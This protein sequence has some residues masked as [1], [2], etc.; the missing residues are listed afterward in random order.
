MRFI[1]QIKSHIGKDLNVPEYK[2]EMIYFKL[3]KSGFE[4]YKNN[5]F[6]GV[7]NKNYRV[8]T[9]NQKYSV[10][11]EVYFCNTHPHQIYIEMLSEHG[12]IGSF[13]IFFILYKLIFSKIRNVYDE[14]NYIQIGSLIYI[15]LTFYLYYLQVLFLVTIC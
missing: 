8:V 13:L 12:L 5:K 2:R 7:G 9:C 11:K 15:T 10:F 1:N 6:F 14:R 4:V 3:Y